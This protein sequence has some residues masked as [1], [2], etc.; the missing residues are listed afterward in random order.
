MISARSTD[1]G[2]HSYHRYVGG[3]ND[4]SPTIRDL[5]KVL[6]EFGR[7]D[8]AAFLKFVTSCSKPPLLG[9]AHMHP[10][11]CIQCVSE[12]GSEVRSHISFLYL[13]YISEDGSEVRSALSLPCTSPMSPLHLS[14]ASLPCISIGALRARL[15]WYGPEGNGAV[16]HSLDLL[17]SAQAA[18]LQVE[19]EPQGEAPLRHPLGH[20]LR[21]QLKKRNV[22][23]IRLSL[24]ETQL[25]SAVQPSR[26]PTNS[27]DHT[28]DE[29]WSSRVLL[30]ARARVHSR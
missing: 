1:D 28:L 21:A 7:E 8:R 22:L 9:F 4:L 6:E 25:K 19:E 23:V 27:D 2:G 5:W 24:R 30:L 13:P 14:P 16:A 17:Q 12:D 29:V 10:S 15:L 11:F 26:R 18:Q 3:Y 20:R